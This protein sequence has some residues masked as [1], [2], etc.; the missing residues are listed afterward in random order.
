MPTSTIAAYLIKSGDLF[1]LKTRH[2]NT[3]G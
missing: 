3:K 2:K 1:L